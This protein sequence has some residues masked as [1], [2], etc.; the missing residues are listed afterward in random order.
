MNLQHQATLDWL[1]AVL[2]GI[3]RRLLDSE[4]LDTPLLQ[5]PLAQLRL[6]QAL[7]PTDP[8][9]ETMG[10]LSERLGVGHSALTQAADRL[11]HN[12]LAERM[13]DAHDRRVVRLRLTEKGTEWVTARRNR[14]RARL[15]QLFTLLSEEEQQNLI[16]AVKTLEAAAGRLSRPAGASVNDRSEGQAALVEETI[17]RFAI[18]NQGAPG[19]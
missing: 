7:Y 16:S 15:A 17:S 18:V 11:I 9:G 14:R 6:A 1:E 4:D 5:L 3:M 8:S 13:A 10:R 19:S 12:G 2:P